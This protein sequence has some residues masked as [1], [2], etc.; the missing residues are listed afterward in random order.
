MSSV[1]K[2]EGVIFGEVTDD[3]ESGEIIVTATLESFDSVKHW[4]R[5]ASMKRGLLRDNSSRQN[6]VNQLIGGSVHSNSREVAVHRTTASGFLLELIRCTRSDRRLTCELEVLNNG[7]DR[8][9]GV[10]PV[11]SRVLDE[12]SSQTQG[13]EAI[14]AGRAAAGY[15]WARQTL[16]SSRPTKLTITF[17]GIASRATTIGRLELHCMGTEPNSEFNVVF[18]NIPIE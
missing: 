15:N 14:V 17:E 7:E 2:A 10:F 9:F 8:D 6:A 3:K 4:K 16:L 18:R 1:E 12:S 11:N 13:N 5:F